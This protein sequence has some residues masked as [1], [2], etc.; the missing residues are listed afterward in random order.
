MSDKWY[1]NK[2]SDKIWWKDTP[3]DLGLWIFSFDREE[4][5]NMFADYP[6]KLTEDQIRI[7]DQENPEWAQFFADRKR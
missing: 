7:F 2:E 1:K 5:F 3:E 4:E 6:F